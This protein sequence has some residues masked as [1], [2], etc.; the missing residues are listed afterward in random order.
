MSGAVDGSRAGFETARLA[1]ARL[2]LDGDDARHSA[3]Q[4]LARVSAHALA[5]ERVGVWLF[6]D[7]SRQLRN[8]GQYLRGS[9]ETRAPGEPIETAPY[10]GYL[11]AL[12]DRRVLAITETRTNAVAR[13]LTGSAFAL[14]GTTARL[15]APIIREGVVA[16]VVCHEHVG[17]A[18]I[19]SQKDRDFA[20]ST[21]DMAAL[22]LEQADRL[23]IELALRERRESKLM[24][25]KMA[26]LSRLA[27]AVAHDINNVF[28]VLGMTG[29]LLE[30]SQDEEIHRHG[31]SIQR[32]VGLGGRLVQQ[33]ALFGEESVDSN[34]RVDLG[35][36]VD[37]MRPVLADLAQGIRLEIAMLTP[38]PLI[39]ANASQ[40]EQVVLNLCVNAFESISPAPDGR[41]RIELRD[42]HPGEAID[43]ASVVLSVADSGRGMDAETQA[44][45]FEP[46]FT[47]KAGGHGIGLSVVYGIVKRCR[48]SITVHSE[49]GAGATFVIALPMAA[50]R[51]PLR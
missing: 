49:P 42:P 15:D 8:L 20:A 44:H 21:A 4:T 40:I 31:E 25:D 46:Y 12:R 35:A 28:N 6:A 50:A 11:A 2:R 18:R 22:F 7:S 23:E 16:G 27:R 43:P 34:A 39:V 5:V 3:M 13:E 14:T 1:L 38:A 48:G 33:L 9:S 26:A 37:R 41:V 17:E 29:F 51:E 10:P 30:E 36:V 24:E 32:A 47:R 45:I 19:W